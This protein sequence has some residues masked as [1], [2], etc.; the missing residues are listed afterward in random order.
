[1]GGI[2]AQ[3]AFADLF[4]R[5]LAEDML[6]L[7]G[8]LGG[9]LLVHAQL[10]KEVGQQL[11]A[12]VNALSDLLPGL[13]QGQVAFAVHRDI[14]VLPQLFHGDAHAGFGKAQ[15][16]D[17]VNGAHFAHTLAQ[18]QDRFKIIF[19]GLVDLHGLSGLLP[20]SLWGIFPTGYVYPLSYVKG[21]HIFA[22]DASNSQQ[23]W[24]N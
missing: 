5:L 18:H 6:C 21:Y 2:I 10:H 12:A 16:I 1:M 22:V 4:Q 11:V 15:L 3:G 7:A 8:V 17:N 9:G 14:A 19:C 23:V 20:Y 13:Q 24:L